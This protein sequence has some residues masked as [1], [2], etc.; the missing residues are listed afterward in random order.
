MIQ[1]RIIHWCR[2][3]PPDR[4]H[5][6]RQPQLH[7]HRCHPLVIIII[8]HFCVAII[9]T[10]PIG[11]ITIAIIIHRN[12]TTAINGL[13]ITMR[14]KLIFSHLV[15]QATMVAAMIRMIIVVTT[16]MTRMQRLPI[17]WR[18]QNIGE[19]RGAPVVQDLHYH[20]HPHSH[21]RI[22]IVIIQCLYTN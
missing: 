14:N 4:P 1:T 19:G 2:Q 3:L 21:H 15:N 8:I 12:N 6:P 10:R 16:A 20:S 7:P 18:P 5:R 22:A 13:N 17:C 9:H 11:I